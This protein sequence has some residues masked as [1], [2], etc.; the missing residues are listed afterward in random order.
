MKNPDILKT[1]IQFLSE[2]SILM[3]L[4]F[5]HKWIFAPISEDIQVSN[6]LI[7]RAKNTYYLQIRVGRILK[8]LGK[9]G[10]L[11]KCFQ[12]KKLS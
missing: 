10:L 6:D 3:K 2:N 4:W 11:E 5:G 7:F 12:F 1:K 9:S 8:L